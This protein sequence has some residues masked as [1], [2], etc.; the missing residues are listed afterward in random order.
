MNSPMTVTKYR[1]ACLRVQD[2][3]ASI[4]IDPGVFSPDAAAV[5]GLSAVLIT[6]GHPDHVD[7]EL[8]SAILSAN[9]GAAVYADPAT[10][11]AL[12]R[13]GIDARPTQ[14][15]DTLDLGT[16][17]RVFGENHAVIHRDV[18]VIPNRGYLIGDRLFHP[19]DALTVPDVR[20]EILALPAMAPWMAVK[21]AVEYERAVAPRVAFPIH[22]QMLSTTAT[23][24]RLLSTLKPHETEWVDLDDGASREF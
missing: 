12:Q 2:G 16:S 17:V 13:A 23:V 6:H 5:T 1:H 4:L 18:P 20:V 3:D 21:E 11:D 14:P 7:P 24:Y 10:V 22:E 15:G 8:L 9:P 19:G